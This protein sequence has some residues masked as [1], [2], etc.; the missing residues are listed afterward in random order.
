[1]KIKTEDKAGFKRAYLQLSRLE[2]LTDVVYALVIWHAFSLIP[3]PTSEE[4]SGVVLGGFIADNAAAFAMVF[5]TIAVCIIYWV[6]N[7]TLF[8]NLE[9]TDTRHTALSILQVFFLL[10]FLF[11]MKLGIEMG[12]SFRTRIFESV[13]AALVGITG[14]WAWSYAIR[15]RRLLL[16][17]VTDSYARQLQDRT[18]A[19]PITATITIFLAF[20]GPVFWEIG[21]LSYPII[22]IL[23]RRRR[24]RGHPVE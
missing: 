1:M 16:P 7:N 17:E 4:W 24:E 13:T 6:Q 15:D 9:R 10:M 2:R 11:S 8:G 5:I 23:V 19:E 3:T 18:L 14:G 12:G 21:W 22:I 20:A